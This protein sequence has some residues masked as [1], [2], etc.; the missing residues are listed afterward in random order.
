[1]KAAE[2]KYNFFL[3][4]I[5]ADVCLITHQFNCPFA[6]YFR[7][8]CLLGK[9]HAFFLVSST[10]EVGNIFLGNNYSK[11]IN[12]GNQERGEKGYIDVCVKNTSIHDIFL[13]LV[14][15]LA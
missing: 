4:Y 9:G 8:L 3:I 13:K 11:G 2:V 14:V 6:L 5:L 10:L 7:L 15:F 1:M 12:K